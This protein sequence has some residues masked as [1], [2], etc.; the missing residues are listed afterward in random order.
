MATDSKAID[1]SAIQALL[2]RYCVSDG[3]SFRAA[4]HATDDMGGLALRKKEGREMLR[5]SVRRLSELQQKLEANGSWAM[6]VALQ[7]MDAGGK[8]ST[9]KH[10]MSGVNPQGVAVTAFKQPGPVELSHDFLW[11][12]HFSIPARGKIGIFNRSHYEEVLVTRVHPE[13]LEN[14]KLPAAVQGPHFWTHRYEDIRNF[15]TYLSRQGFVV[16][17]FFL[18]GSREKQRQRFLK[19][20]N[21]PDK[22]WKFSPSDIRERGY[23]DDYQN[24][25]HEAVAHTAQ[26]CAPWYVVPGD[27]KW[28]ARL[29]V[30]EAMIAALEKLDLGEPEPAPEVR[31]SLKK[32]RSILERE[33][34]KGD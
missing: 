10:V 18:N 31:D 26:P 15:E 27:R 21:R 5:A 16:L 1:R 4:D 32:F 34:K 25:Y 24:A 6:L 20:L 33:G 2:P 13:V 7:A 3:A 11:R 9:I 30:I 19:R 12:P 17:K 8:D 22:V 23:W 28:F 14:E 29:V